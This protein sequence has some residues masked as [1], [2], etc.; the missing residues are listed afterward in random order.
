M[1]ELNREVLTDLTA[2]ELEERLEMA[3]AAAADSCSSL[4]CIQYESNPAPENPA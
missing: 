1:K 2:E 3:E 4:D